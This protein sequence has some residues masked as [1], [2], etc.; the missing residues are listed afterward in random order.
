MD[1]NRQGQGKGKRE[2]EIKTMSSRYG[3]PC[4][5]LFFIVLILGYENYETWSSPSAVPPKKDTG[6]KG[7]TK[8]EPPISAGALKAT[9][10]REAF[11]TIAEKNVFNPDRKEFAT[12][13][14]AAAGGKP[15]VRPQI[16]LYG[17][18]IGHDYQIASVINPGRPLHKG[19]REMK[20]LKI[21]DMVGDYKL[22]KITQ[23]RI[24]MEAGEDSFE[25]LLYDPRVP[26]KRMEARTPTQPATVT[27]TIPTPIPPGATQ[28]G[29]PPG[30]PAVVTPPPA[31]TPAP[32]PRSAGP[33]PV[34][35]TPGAAPGVNQPPTPAV[36]PTPS[37]P[38]DPGVWR[39]RR[40]ISPAPAGPSG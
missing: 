31:M 2:G 18:V 9:T 37:T 3:I 29:F 7:E 5:L 24:V 20:T 8:P 21:G 34:P 26:K 10:P 12:V 1:E 27:S 30:S 14:A 22:T 6:K 13:E 15:V 33:L 38:P 17:V 28:P 11:N 40:P 25:V 19:E 32:T 39:G 23:D 4:I 35:R 36:S 16:T